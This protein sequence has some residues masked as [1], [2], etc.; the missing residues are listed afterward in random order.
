MIEALLKIA[1]TTVAESQLTEIAKNMPEKITNSSELDKPIAKYVDEKK[2]Y[3][4]VDE[5]L[6]NASQEEKDIYNKANLEKGEVNGRESLQRTDLDYNEKDSFGRTNLERMKEG[7][8]PLKD[9]QPI[10]LHHIGQEMDSPLAELTSK[11]HRGPG[12]DGVL[13]DK[14]KD[15]EIDRNEFNKERESYW[16][17][18]AE[19]IE[20]RGN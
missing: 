12:N 2:E 10:E 20:D 1:E 4:T 3:K 13:H 8:A 6:E 7:L 16:K 19:Q 18:R 15:S 17:A 14:K 11:E 9:G 5:A